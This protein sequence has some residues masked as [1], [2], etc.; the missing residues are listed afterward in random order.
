[1]K[2]RIMGT[3]AENDKL[4]SALKRAIEIDIISI[5]EPYA[6]RGY[7]KEE[8]IYIECRIDITYTPADVIDELLLEV[9]E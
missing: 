7:N 6:N 8:R 4:I 1:M 5:S 3:P 9:S 2:I